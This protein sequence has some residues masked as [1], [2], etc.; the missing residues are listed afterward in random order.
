MPLTALLIHPDSERFVPAAQGICD[1]HNCRPF[2]EDRIFPLRYQ[3]WGGPHMS[4]HAGTEFIPN[5]PLPV[6]WNKAGDRG[7]NI[8]TPLISKTGFAR[9]E[10]SS[11]RRTS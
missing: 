2:S 11:W 7:F 10:N 8:S 4:K 1:V 5:R 9:D 6:Y 3:R